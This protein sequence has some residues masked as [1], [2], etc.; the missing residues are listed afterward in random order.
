M[1][2]PQIW[3]VKKMKSF[4]NS[5][6]PVRGLTV[7]PFELDGKS[8][9]TD[10]HVWIVSRDPDHWHIEYNDKPVPSNISGVNFMAFPTIC[11]STCALRFRIQEAPILPEAAKRVCSRSMEPCKGSVFLSLSQTVVTPSELRR[12]LSNTLF[13]R[14]SRQTLDSNSPMPLLPFRVNTPPSAP[15]IKSCCPG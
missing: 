4:R 12:I 2:G 8:I 11:S 5:M 14:V 7:E 9:Q 1:G 10:T 13:S 6:E 15:F 3:A